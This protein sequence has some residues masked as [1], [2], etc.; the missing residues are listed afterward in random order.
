V[1]VNVKGRGLIFA[2]PAAYA[3]D[4]STIPWNIQGGVALICTL[5]QSPFVR[6]PVEDPAYNRRRVKFALELTPDFSV[7]GTL[8]V[9]YFGQESA[10]L[11][12]RLSNSSA[13][14]RS[15]HFHLDYA[16]RY[17]GVEIRNIQV[18]GFMP[19]ESAIRVTCDI[20]IPD[21]IDIDTGRMDFDVC[22]LLCNPFQGLT[23]QE[24]LHPLFMPYPYIIETEI[25]LE[26]G[27]LANI[28]TPPSFSY[29]SQSGGLE[30]GWTRN[31]GVL[32]LESKF[33]WKR[34]FFPAEDWEIFLDFAVQIKSGM[35][36]QKLMI[37]C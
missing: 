36:S 29:G 32:K 8:S 27:T 21:L 16:R 26:T 37:E 2:N 7:A 24:R 35:A 17:S 34:L 14:E 33:L 22:S 25:E 9:E 11:R 23:Q 3:G 5:Y 1:A 28:V 6:L 15:M 4:A 20:E 18:E 12:K 30:I 19:D 13:R 31:G 10:D